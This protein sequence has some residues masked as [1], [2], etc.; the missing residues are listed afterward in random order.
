MASAG[1]AA[2]A[3][4][5]LPGGLSVGTIFDASFR[6]GTTVKRLRDAVTSGKPERIPAPLSN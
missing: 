3:R 4:H 1:L 6:I 2:V 5:K